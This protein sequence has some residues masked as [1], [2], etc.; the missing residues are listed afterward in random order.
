MT[1][2]YTHTHLIQGKNYWM[3][4]EKMSSPSDLLPIVELMWSYCQLICGQN[5]VTLYMF[6]KSKCCKHMVH[7]YYDKKIRP[8]HTW[9]RRP[10]LTGP[11]KHHR[12]TSSN[13]PE[14]VKN[15][16]FQRSTEWQSELNTSQHISNMLLRQ[17]RNM[18]CL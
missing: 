14:D 16:F 10:F 17:I 1:V 11:F 15:P 2:L 5:P 7:C 4:D 12:P 3:L 18:D 13:H 6:N 9:H 8:F